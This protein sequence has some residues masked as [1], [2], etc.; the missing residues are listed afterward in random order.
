MQQ[1]MPPLN[2]LKAFEAAA[3]TGGYVPAA[4]ELGVSPSA[5]RQEGRNLE[6]FFD[7]Q[8]FQRYHNRITLT[9][10]GIAI[11]D[12]TAQALEKLVDMT[13]R[14]LVGE[15][16]TRLVI[17]LLPSLAARWP[18]RRLSE[19]LEAEG[20]LRVDLR[21]EEDPVDF[22]R[23]NIDLRICYGAHLYPDLAVMPLVRDEVL[24]LATP[25]FLARYGTG[26]P[27]PDLIADD[28]LIHTG[29]GPSFASHPTWSDWF[30]AIGAERAPEVGKGHRVGMSSLAIDL[31]LMGQGLALGQRLLARDEIAD[32]R[33]RAPFPR[34]IPLG[35]P[36]CAV[37]AH[38]KARKPGI[39]KCVDWLTSTARPPGRQEAPR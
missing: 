26:D 10:A 21:V 24:P 3:R 14:V 31:A 28:D 16:R 36:Y 29:W 25:G 7:K 37:H 2:A 34:S 4:R 13:S 33:L 22:A 1:R 32:G 18:G 27:G 12:E 19:F 11:Y 8:R 17:S 6:L 38:S 39:Q 5:V 20:H 15:A 23:H 9:D 30:A 35:H